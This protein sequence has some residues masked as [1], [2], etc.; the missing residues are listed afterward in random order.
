MLHKALATLIL[1][2]K[3]HLHH[4]QVVNQGCETS[5][6]E[7]TEQ[8]SRHKAANENQ[9]NFFLSQITV[10]EE[11]LMTRSQELNKTVKIGLNKLNCFLQQD[12]KLDIS[13]GTFKGK[14]N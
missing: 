8:L 5:S 12:L 10:D 13:T 3:S 14:L 7:I 1:V 9:Q 2:M 6:L 4:L 11:E